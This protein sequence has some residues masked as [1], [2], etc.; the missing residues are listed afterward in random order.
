[1]HPAAV[2]RG[3]ELR[4]VAESLRASTAAAARLG[5]RELPAVTSG[6]RVFQGAGAL[7][8]A[9]A[10]MQADPGLTGQAVGP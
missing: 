10:S 2:L 5:V 9:A 8:E 4:S 3:A 6:G 7:E 1:M